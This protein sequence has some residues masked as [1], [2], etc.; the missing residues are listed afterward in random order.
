MSDKWS[1][2]L[3]DLYQKS[4]LRR[5]VYDLE[6]ITRLHKYL[7]EPSKDYLK[8]HV[9]GTNGKGSFTFKTAKLLEASGY[10]VGMFTSPHLTSFRER[11]QVNSQPV[12]KE[13]LISFMEFL[14]SRGEVIGE[15]L[16][17][18]D[19]QVL[20]AYQYF[21]L[22]KVDVAVIE[23][24]MGG[25]LDSTNVIED[26]ISCIITNI[27]LDHTEV[28][29][30]TKQD[31]LRHKL[32]I[33]KPKAKLVIGETVDPIPCQAA[34]LEKQCDL[35]RVLKPQ[36]T[37]DQDWGFMESIN[38]MVIQNALAIN[39]SLKTDPNIHKQI[40]NWSMSCRLQKI[41]SP[42]PDLFS[43]VML[44]VGH[45]P[46]AIGQVLKHLSRD[47]SVGKLTVLYGGKTNKDL[48]SIWKCFS[49][50]SQM[51]EH[52]H[53]VE[54]G[55]HGYHQQQINDMVNTSTTSNRQK[56]EYTARGRSLRDTLTDIFSRPPRSDPSPRRL[57][58]IGS[59]HLMPSAFQFFNIPAEI[60][61]VNMN[62]T[63]RIN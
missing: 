45:N 51:I 23:V 39:S 36:N 32:G 6:R 26:P 54:M 1:R 13:F 59:F 18:F 62:D 46:D 4:K 34:C 8:I 19:L 48:N 42:R 12:D 17:M 10:K 61:E 47:T 27:A 52:V 55:G 24:G 44:D 3:R 40:P 21:K 7:G 53:F 30:P 63:Y 28:L 56:V 25:L 29:G 58:I 14:E 35:I 57:L 33:L 15:T 5:I 11:I 37:R 20:Q 43:Q 49:E 16:T 60:D 9:T 22:Q 31:I 38:E 41:Q 50:Y 2:Y